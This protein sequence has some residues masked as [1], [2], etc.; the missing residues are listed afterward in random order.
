MGYN[1][2]TLWYNLGNSYVKSG[3]TGSAVVAY[4]RA[5][6]FAPRD[7][8]L[9]ENLV[10]IS[11]PENLRKPFILLRP[12]VSL[13]HYFSLNELFILCE[14]LYVF[15]CVVIIASLL[16]VSSVVSS[17]ARRLIKPILILFVIFL[18]FF[19]VNFYQEVM[20]TYGV[21][22]HDKTIARSGPGSEFTEI[23]VLPEGTK[24]RL[25]AE[26]SDG[27][28]KIRIPDGQTGYIPSSAFEKI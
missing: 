8:D 5:R 2:P 3:K 28:A 24:F 9:R 17:I 23:M 1:S 25:L 26:Q 6:R 27:W 21:I 14:I 4:E 20:T 18:V 22:I 7:S 12:F 19:A 15:L 13:I 16:K 11:P 10:L